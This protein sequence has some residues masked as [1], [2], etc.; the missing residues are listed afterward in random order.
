MEN[1]FEITVPFY[2]VDSMKVVWHGNYVKYF[3][4]ARCAFLKKNDMT[5]E[6]ME[7]TGYAFPVVELNIKYIKP[8]TFGQKIS[9]ETTLE[10][11]SNLLIFHYEIRDA[12]TNERLC[13]ATT[14]Q[15]CVE[16]KTKKS[17]FEIPTF[18]LERLMIK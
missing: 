9:I 7:K 6:D 4:D 17:L 11:C 3:E 13:K 10:N 14:K 12:K 1:L 18:I 16:I 5:Y 15:M 2:D 8:C